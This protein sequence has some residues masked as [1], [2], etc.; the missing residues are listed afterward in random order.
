MESKSIGELAADYL[1]IKFVIEGL[2]GAAADLH[3]QIKAKVE[4]NGGQGFENESLKVEAV[5]GRT[6]E[7]L[8][9][10]KLVVQGVTAEQL[11]AATVRTTSKPTV[12]VTRK[13]G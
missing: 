13:N 1:E 7:K 4:A 9:R 6:T 12:R 8:D 5:K 3:E 11:E 2:E 10:A